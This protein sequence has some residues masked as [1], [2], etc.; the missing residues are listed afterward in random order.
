MQPVIDSEPLK[1][2]RPPPASALPP[3]IVRPDSA[4]ERTLCT[5][6]RLAPLA[7][8]ES[9]LA[10]GPS[11]TGAPTLPSPISPAV[12]MI[13]RGVVPKTDGSKLTVLVPSRVFARLIAWRRSSWP[14]PEPRPS[15]VTLTTID[16]APWV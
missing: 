3:V 5:K 12:S 14:R 6:T 4:T 15:V 9:R 13:V 7:L 1:F 10:P 11:T 16:A 2:F 8:I